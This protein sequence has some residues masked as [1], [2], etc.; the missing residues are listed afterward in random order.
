[1]ITHA[2]AAMQGR[3]DAMVFSDYTKQR[4]LFFRMQG[5]RPPKIADLLLQE[6]ISAR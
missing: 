6:G 3:V 1:M 5:Y 2:H 4:I